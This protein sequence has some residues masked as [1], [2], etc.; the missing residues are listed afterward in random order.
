MSVCHIYNLQF[1]S[2]VGQDNHKVF[3]TKCFWREKQNAVAFYPP[4]PIDHAD[5][6]GSEGCHTPA[7][8]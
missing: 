7:P 3:S 6:L 4:V 8:L 2:V 5:N 1:L